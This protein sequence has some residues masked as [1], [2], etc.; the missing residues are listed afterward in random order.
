M[1]VAAQATTQRDV[2]AQ[3]FI[4]RMRPEAAKVRGV[5]VYLQAGQDLTFGGRLSR[6]Q[7]QYTLTSI[8]TGELNHW[9][10]ILDRR[11]RGLPEVQDNATDQQI[12]AR[13][14]AIEVDRDI[15]S[16]LGI[17][18]SAIDQT[19]YDTFGQRQV[20]TIYTPATQYRVVLESTANFEKGPDALSRHLRPGRQRRAGAAERRGALHQH[21]GSARHQPPGPVSRR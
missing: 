20:A 8:D 4:Q 2:S 3:Q 13:H 14:V 7:Y 6:T 10:P 15:A 1:F 9:A 21:G 17:S 11:M 12:A 5:N 18:L 16:R 19:L